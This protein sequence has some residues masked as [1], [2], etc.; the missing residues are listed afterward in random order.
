MR[1][2]AVRV[3]IDGAGAA[4]R[5]SSRCTWLVLVLAALSAGAIAFTIC[6]GR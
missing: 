5:P 1:A 3:V 2:R 6:R 4:R